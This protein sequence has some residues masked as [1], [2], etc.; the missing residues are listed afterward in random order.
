MCEGFC[1]SPCKCLKWLINGGYEVLTNWGDSPSK[2]FH[3]IFQSG[4]LVKNSCGRKLQCK[5]HEGFKKNTNQYNINRWWQP[6]D[7]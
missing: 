2:G 1:C 3:S 4:G 5:S 7:S 6:K